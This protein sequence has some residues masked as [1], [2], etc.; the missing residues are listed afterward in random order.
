MFRRD[1]RNLFVPEHQDMGVHPEQ[2]HE[3]VQIP[4]DN[5]AA[6]NSYF[7]ISI[8]E[9][10]VLVN[11]IVLECVVSGVNSSYYLPLCFAFSRI[12][13]LCG[14]NVLDTLYPEQQFLAHQFW[15]PADEKRA[16]YNAGIG[17]YTSTVSRTTVTGT[18][19]TYQIPIWSLFK[20]TNL[21]LIF[22]NQ[23]I[24]LR[25]Y[26][27]SSGSILYNGSAA[28]TTGT[29]TSCKALVR[30]TRM[31]EYDAN[32]LKFDIVK[33]PQHRKFHELRQMTFQQASGVTTSSIVLSG[34][35]GRV[36]SIFFIVRTSSPI[37]ENKLAFTKISSFEYVDG[38]GKNIV[39]GTTISDSVSRYYQSRQFTNT[40]YLGEDKTL[41][42]GS[43]PYVYIY[44][45]ALNAP[46]SEITGNDTGAHHFKGNEVLRINYVS[47]TASAYQI[48]IYAMTQSAIEISALSTKKISIF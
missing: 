1:N 48:D 47:T 22:P 13:I 17:Q 46:V 23:K 27:E 8:N 45:W 30:L 7:T 38:S 19:Y 15:L 2:K 34:I 25:L 39:G 36:S 6:L 32:K 9:Q 21:P 5:T 44:S 20:T 4:S 35:V 24:Q 12:E 40:S 42:S 29:M 18:S 11:D 28:V 10:N 43:T 16:L 31:T 41:T 33:I 3:L 14:S 26:T 37:C